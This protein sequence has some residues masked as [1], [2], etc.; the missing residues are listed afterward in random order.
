MCSSKYRSF[1]LGAQIIRN[2]GHFSKPWT[3]FSVH[4]DGVQEE[5]IS[6]YIIWWLLR[7]HCA[8]L[9]DPD[10]DCVRWLTI[11]R[12][13]IPFQ[14]PA[15]YRATYHVSISTHRSVIVHGLDSR[16]KT[17]IYIITYEYWNY[18]IP[19]KTKLPWVLRWSTSPLL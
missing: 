5:P 17:M 18:T 12:H 9:M 8:L 7:H 2:R 14:K 13:T 1:D 4:L 10:L 19:K 6:T 15:G 16:N 11:L 3:M